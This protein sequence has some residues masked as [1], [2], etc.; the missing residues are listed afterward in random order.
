ML[1]GPKSRKN[2][3]NPKRKSITRKEK[4]SIKNVMILKNFSMVFP[5]LT[6]KG[7]NKAPMKN[8][9]SEFLICV[10]TAKPR[11]LTPYSL[12]TL[13]YIVFQL[14]AHPGANCHLIFYC[15]YWIHDSRPRHITNQAVFLSVYFF[16]FPCSKGHS[17]RA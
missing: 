16:I 17:V 5:P 2:L 12:I 10:G 1:Q 3:R 9:S 8:Y 6:T 13:P 11:L 7:D 15:F 4:V 14:K